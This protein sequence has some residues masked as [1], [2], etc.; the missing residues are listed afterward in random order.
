VHLGRIQ[1]AYRATMVITTEEWENR[2]GQSTIPINI[3]LVMDVI[4]LLL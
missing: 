2:S 3:T 4:I 1:K